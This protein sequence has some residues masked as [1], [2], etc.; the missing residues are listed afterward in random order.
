[1]E[2]LEMTTSSDCVRSSKRAHQE[3]VVAACGV[4]LRGARELRGGR[5]VAHHAA[6]VRE[7]GGEVH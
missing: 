3:A 5:G 6:D 2:S 7:E 1:M 4:D